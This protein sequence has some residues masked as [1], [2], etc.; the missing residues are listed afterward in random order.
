[1]IERPH[2]S[3][4]R[5]STER[6]TRPAEIQRLSFGDL[7][8]SNLKTRQR[9]AEEGKQIVPIEAARLGDIQVL[10]AAEPRTNPPKPTIELDGLARIP[11]VE[12]VVSSTEITLGTDLPSVTELL[13]VDAG[14]IAPRPETFAL[15]PNLHSLHAT[16]LHGQRKLSLSS[17][18]GSDLR[19]LAITWNRI[20]PGDIG[21]V[22]SFS[23]LR[24][25]ALHAGPGDSVESVGQLQM[26]EYLFLE[27]GRS[28]WARL[29][30][31]GRVEEAVLWDAR[32]TDLHSLSGWARLR[33]LWLRGRRVKSLAGINALRALDILCLE[34]LGITDLTPM[35]GLENLT[36]LKLTGVALDDLG[37]LAGLLSLRDITLF[38]ANGGWRVK[39]LAALGELRQLEH[40]RLR[41]VTIGDFDLSALVR[42]P[43]LTRLELFPATYLDDRVVAF[44]KLRPDVSVE[45]QQD[46]GAP[47]LW[48]GPVEVHPPSENLADWWLM[49][50]LTGLLG[51]ATNAEAEGRLQAAIHQ[52]S[53]DLLQRLRFDTEAA[54]VGVNA[55]S[56]A[57]I[58][59]VAEVIADLSEPQ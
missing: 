43:N 1:M 59:E 57:D 42:L 35:R 7:L 39:S 41:G 25:L 17:L 32:L 14:P 29:A 23:E 12:S 9:T 8:Q 16:T 10:A 19:D 15:L 22:G 3:F 45:A 50:D 24:R 47:S 37:P 58:R 52:R 26:L 34:V 40:V 2:S 38:G 27:G 4:T 44:R 48:I 56:E 20:Q 21:N 53:R 33:S 36:T 30:L 28:G 54:A 46:V 55:Q 6:K 51:T 13:F 5:T 11:T 49:Q 31:L 18:G